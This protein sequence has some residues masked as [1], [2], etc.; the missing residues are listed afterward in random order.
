MSHQHQKLQN[1]RIGARPR[2]LQ[3]A[4]TASLPKADGTPSTWCP[5]GAGRVGNLPESLM[6]IPQKPQTV[7]T[8]TKLNSSNVVL[9]KYMFRLIN[10]TS[11]TSQQ[12]QADTPLQHLIE[13]ACS[14][15]SLYFLQTD[16]RDSITQPLCVQLLL[17]C[18]VSCWN[19]LLLPHLSASNHTYIQREGK[20]ERERERQRLKTSGKPSTWS[21]LEGL[22]E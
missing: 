1:L 7:W 4:N 10:L 6:P 16:N 20:R 19:H 12:F 22:T 15:R 11:T 18:F 17:K 8:K 2:K 14:D 21:P 3:L 13:V 9:Y 5:S